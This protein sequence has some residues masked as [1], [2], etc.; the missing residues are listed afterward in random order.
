MSWLKKRGQTASPNPLAAPPVQ[1]YNPNQHSNL[2]TQWQ[3]QDLQAPSSNN[4]YSQTQ[5]NQQSLQQPPYSQPV[6]QPNNWNRSYIQQPTNTYNPN[7]TNQYTEQYSSY[8]SSYSNENSSYQQTNYANQQPQNPTYNY[9]QTSEPQSNVNTDSWNWGWGDE[10]NSNVQNLPQANSTLNVNHVESSNEETWNWT[11]EDSNTNSSD[12]HALDSHS[13]T[14]TNKNSAHQ[15]TQHTASQPSVFPQMGKLAEKHSQSTD[16]Y[17]Q[18]SNCESSLN[19][20]SLAYS[21]H[22]TL[23]QAV[24]SSTLKHNKIDHLTPQWSTE[25]QMSQDSSDLLH[26]S[27]SDKS[28]MLSRSSTISESPVSGHDINS[29]NVI[30][31]ESPQ[32]RHHETSNVMTETSSSDSVSMNYYRQDAYSLHQENKEDISGLQEELKQYKGNSTI[33]P[34][35]MTNQTPPHVLPLTDDKP[36]NPYKLNTGLSH[37]SASKHNLEPRQSGN[38][39]HQ[40]KYPVSQSPFNQLVNLETLPDNAEQPDTISHISKKVAVKPSVHQWPD[41]NEV[42]PINDRNQYLETG[43]LSNNECNQ[44]RSS[45][46]NDTSD[47][48][49]PPGFTRMVLGQMEQT[50]N[51]GNQDEPPPGLSRMVLGETCATSSL[52]KPDNAEPLHRMIPGG[53]S[54]PKPRYQPSSYPAPKFGNTPPPPESDLNVHVPNQIRSATIG[55]DTPSVTTNVVTGASIANRSMTI[56]ADITMPYSSTN[57]ESTKPSSKVPSASSNFNNNIRE[58]NLE[59]ASNLDEKITTPVVARRD[60]IEGETQDNSVTNLVNSIRDLNVGENLNNSTN[61]TLPITERN[62]RRPSKQESTDSEQES[63]AR[64]RKERRYYEKHGDYDRERNRR[65]SPSP[66]RYREKKY[67]RT[68]Y[69]DPRYDDD[70]DYYS[71]KDRDRKRDDKDRRE[72]LDKKYGSL[73]RD[74]EKRRKEQRNYRDY[75][76]DGHRKDYYHRYEDEYDDHSRSRPSSRSDSLHDSYRQDRDRHRDKYRRHRDPYNMPYMQGYSYDPYNPYYQQ[77]QYHYL[78]NLRRTNPQ[79]YAEWYRKYYQQSNSQQNFGNEDRASV[80]SGR[81]SANEEL[82]K[83]RPFDQTDSSLYL[84]D[85]TGASQRL[86]PAKF[87]TAHV[88]AS[89][90]SGRLVKIFPHYPLDGQPAVVEVNNLK[91]LLVND[92]EYKE[93][94]EFPGPL[95]KGVTH[96][97]TIIEYC[98]NKIRSAIYS[99]DIGDVDSYILMW[100]L[101]ILLL[102]Q[103]GMVVGTDIAELLM[104]DKKQEYSRKGSITSN[105]SEVVERALSEPNLHTDLTGSS[106]SILKEEVVTNKFRELLIYGSEKEA[107]E[108]SMKHGLWGHALFLASK[109]DK[110]TYANVMT[111]FANGLT[112]NDPLQTLYQLLSGKIPASV[113]CVSDEKWGDWRPHLAMI[114]S[115]TTQRPELD[116]KAIMTLGDTLFARNSLYAAQFSYLMA[117]VEFS[118]YG[119]ESPKLVLLGSNHNKPFMEFAI[120][121]AIFMTE[122]YEYAC[123]L[124]DNNFVIP[125][126]LPYKYLLATRLADRGLLDKSLAYLE[127]IAVAVTQNPGLAQPTLIHQVCTLGDRLKYCDIVEDALEGDTECDNRPDTTWLRDLKAFEKNINIHSAPL[128]TVEN[129]ELMA[130]TD[131]NQIHQ[132]AYDQSWPQQYAEE[133]YQQQQQWQSGQY[134]QQNNAVYQQSQSVGTEGYTSELYPDQHSYWTHNQLPETTDHGLDSN[135]Q[136][137]FPTDLQSNSFWNSAPAQHEEVENQ[138][139]EGIPQ[140]SMPHQS[141]ENAER[142]NQENVQHQVKKESPIKQ[143]A[144]DKSA[145]TGWFGGIWNKLSLRPKNQMKLPDDKNPSIVWDEQKKRWI[146]LE[147]EGDGAVAELKPPPKMADMYSAPSQA[148]PTIPGAVAHDNLSHAPGHQMEPTRPFLENGMMPTQNSVGNAIHT[149]MAQ[150][151]NEVHER[152]DD[153]LPKTAQPNMFKLQRGRNIKKSYV[154]V[155]NP[156]AKSAGNAPSIAAPETFSSMPPSGLQMNYFVPAPVSDPNAPMDFLTPAPLQQ[157]DDSSQISRSSSASSLSREVQYYMQNKEPVHR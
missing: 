79:A 63:V 128:D 129:S 8:N 30:R 32:S 121:E 44:P 118:R 106:A 74:K 144:Q 136:Q 6:L 19:Q 89:I 46:L 47:L 25:S 60:S 147:S 37:K 35:P 138:P 133:Q 66:D 148:I 59:G 125:E 75:G 50:D 139:N 98:E 10:D 101:L 45:S 39:I 12:V 88:K 76:R 143:K 31:Q 127:K 3:H 116:R 155:F 11:V 16:V 65:Y 48:I 115:N 146:N 67:E 90:S 97:K 126:F 73:K 151:Q 15:N 22:P 18:D 141:R 20:H 40:S 70:T 156:G 95:I 55:A 24:I 92:D 14:S 103:N 27:E 134:D 108:W 64:D 117:Q 2:Q 41:N 112:M 72:E 5:P 120:N 113:T 29:E 53:S 107:L 84:E 58:T 131:Q 56:G 132:S 57:L 111:R 149:N 114:L 1:M 82:S 78:E 91:E 81:S 145:T 99:R 23:N 105:S 13:S 17:S 104:K 80:H 52:P 71:D 9:T 54:S 38:P 102:R 137:Q 26:T 43:Q 36:K 61:S 100:E 150:G 34:P 87:A 49:P 152:H 140:I 86:T 123:S 94:V 130:G 7:P 68:R 135:T 21:D 28:H 124:N 154:D 109:L 93:L 83:D 122:V 62:T 119:T 110:R 157:I 85:T 4:W 33:P 96:K 42:A 153:G 77:Y 142:D 69:R 51:L